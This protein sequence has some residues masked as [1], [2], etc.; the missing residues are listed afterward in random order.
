MNK[1]K[2]LREV[3]LTILL[4]LPLVIMSSC[5]KNDEKSHLVIEA[6]HNDK[7]AHEA[8]DYTE[9]CVYIV[10]EVVNPGVYLLK[11]EARV[12]DAVDAA[13]GFTEQAAKDYINLASKVS[14]GEKII[15]Y[16]VT[17]INSEIM[18]EEQSSLVNINTANADKLMTLPGIGQSRANDIIKY[19]EKNGRFET[20][21]DIMKVSGIKEAAFSKIEDLITV[22]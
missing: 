7:E 15:V 10:G 3:M 20:I 17:Q 16:S 9:I 13:G 2:K 4:V 22:D 5:G 8:A 6:S 12:C 18:M 19:R 1:I 11:K 21:E 14:D